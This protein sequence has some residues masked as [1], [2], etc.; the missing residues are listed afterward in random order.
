MNALKVAVIVLALLVV[1]EAIAI[2]YLYQWKSVSPSVKTTAPAQGEQLRIV[3]LAPSDTQILIALGLGKYIVGVDKYSY[4][5]LKELNMTYLLPN[6]VTVLGQIYPPNISGILLLK[7]TVVVVE[8]DLIGSYLNQLEEAGLNV[9]VTNNDFASSF[10]QIE[11]NIYEIGKYF[12]RTLQAEELI[13]WMNGMISNFSTSSYNMTNVSF[14]IWINNDYTFYT[15]GGNVFINAVIQ[16]AGGYNVFSSLSGYPELT[17]DRLL[18]ARPQVIMADEMLNS[19][20]TINVI[21]NWPGGSQVPAIKDGRVYVLSG[22]AVDLINEPGPLA[23]YA[24]KMIH[25]ILEGQA[26]HIVNTTW[27]LENVNPELPVFS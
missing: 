26:P 4:E 3:S 17:P 23:V 8:E 13:A 14:L 9:L 1:I 6:N 25:M 2:V 22:L 16:S 5:L 18:L 15:A 27:V 20:Y 7:P 24:I 21:Y 10:S 12:N 19:T 11:N